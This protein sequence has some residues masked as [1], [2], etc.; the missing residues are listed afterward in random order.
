MRKVKLQ[1]GSLAWFHGWFEYLG[2]SYAL[3]ELQD[4]RIEEI[5]SGLLTFLDTPDLNSTE[6]IKEKSSGAVKSIY[7]YDIKVG[8]IVIDSDDIK[9]VVCKEV[10]YRNCNE[11]YRNTDGTC[12]GINCTSNGLIFKLL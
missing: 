12:I 4:G 8:G 2:N 1:D 11:C 3:V 7:D 5:P 6:E 9:S 10:E